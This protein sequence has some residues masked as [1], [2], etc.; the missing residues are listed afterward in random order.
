VRD[1][2]NKS[3]RGEHDDAQ[4]VME[5]KYRTRDFISQFATC[6]SHLLSVLP[7]GV[8]SH[9]VV[10]ADSAQCFTLYHPLQI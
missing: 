2:A 7:A 9:F 4:N 5:T 8:S 1:L 3:G 6:E 10:L